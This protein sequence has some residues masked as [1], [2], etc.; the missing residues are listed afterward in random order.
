MRLYPGKVCQELA[1]FCNLS[2]K[3][4]W[5]IQSTIQMNKEGNRVELVPA[6]GETRRDR[7]ECYKVIIKF[8]WK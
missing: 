4:K 3:Y 7:E 6:P 8:T 1:I 5:G 2:Q